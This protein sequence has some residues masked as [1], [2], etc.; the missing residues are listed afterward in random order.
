MKLNKFVKKLSDL[1]DDDKQERKRQC[2]KL[3]KYLKGLKDKAKELRKDIANEK[4]KGK[5]EEYEEKLK[6][7]N[8]K[9]KKGL[10]LLEQL[11]DKYC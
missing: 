8:T 7:V 11:R 4:D 6:I 10:K 5:R 3:K 9:R 1:A 2:G